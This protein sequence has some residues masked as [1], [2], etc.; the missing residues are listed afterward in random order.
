M[1]FTIKNPLQKASPLQQHVEGH[2]FNL[3]Q[4]LQKERVEETIKNAKNFKLKTNNFDLSQ[5]PKKSTV[6]DNFKEFNANLTKKMNQSSL[7]RATGTADSRGGEAK[8]K[9]FE[10]YKRRLGNSKQ[11]GTADQF[12]T[13]SDL[14]PE[15][16]REAK[17]GYSYR[18]ISN[19]FGGEGKGKNRKYPVL[20]NI[21]QE[22]NGAKTSRMYVDPNSPE[23]GNFVRREMALGYRPTNQTGDNAFDYSYDGAA[24]SYMGGTYNTRSGVD[25]PQEFYDENNFRNPFERTLASQTRGGGFNFNPKESIKKDP[26]GRQEAEALN[27][28]EASNFATEQ[29]AQAMQSGNYE[30]AQAILSAANSRL[31]SPSDDGGFGYTSYRDDGMYGVTGGRGAKGGRYY[32][33][34][35]GVFFGNRT[36]DNL[37]YRTDQASNLYNQDYLPTRNEEIDRAAYNEYLMEKMRQT[38]RDTDYSLNFDT[39]GGERF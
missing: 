17:E 28:R 26:F 4:Q 12:K 39:R 29:Y 3:E 31:Q 13:Y 36:K 5:T 32:L 22:R 10:D 27:A 25:Y 14:G 16:S 24:N 23:Y 6:L 15:G 1:A 21:Y 33:Q 11:Y 34:S 37:Q 19:M 8:E 30:E 7:D 38:V 35:P 20:S 18:P 2:P 9:A